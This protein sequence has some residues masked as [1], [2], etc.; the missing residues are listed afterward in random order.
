MKRYSFV[1][2]G[3]GY[4]GQEAIILDGAFP[5]ATCSMAYVA[6]LCAALNRPVD[7]TVNADR[8]VALHDIILEQQ[9]MLAQWFATRERDG[10]TSKVSDDEKRA[11]Q[12]LDQAGQIVSAA[13]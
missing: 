6:R 2:G 4:Q 9:K 13:L 5:F 7:V 11:V 3:V 1:S 10:F 8:L 12:L